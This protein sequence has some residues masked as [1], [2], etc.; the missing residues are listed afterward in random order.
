MQMKRSIE[1]ATMRDRKSFDMGLLST[2]SKQVG[3]SAVFGP[4]AYWRWPAD[5]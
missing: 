4:L 2:L 3:H 1:A 5:G